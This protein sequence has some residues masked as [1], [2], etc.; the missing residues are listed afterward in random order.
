MTAR[1]D[2]TAVKMDSNRLWITG[3]YGSFDYLDTTE[4]FDLNSG[5]FQP[6]VKLPRKSAEHCLVKVS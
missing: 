1:G 3:G 6:G 2:V 5:R 4:I